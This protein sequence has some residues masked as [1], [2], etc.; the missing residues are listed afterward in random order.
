MRAIVR[1]RAQQLESRHRVHTARRAF[2][3]VDVLVSLG[4]IALLI[5]LMLPALTGI[6]E[7]SRKVVCSSNIRQIG[8][9][10]A[11]Y[12][13][14]YRRNVPFSRFYNKSWQIDQQF[15][16]QTLM[17]AKVAPPTPSAS[18]ANSWDGLGLLFRGNYCSAAQVYYCPSHK[19]AHRYD[20][21]ADGWYGGPID[22]YTNFQY[23]GG[24]A[25]GQTNLDKMGSRISLMADG[26]ASGLDFNH[27]IGGNIVASDLS[28]FWFD[29]SKHTLDL[30]TDY[31]D[32]TAKDKLQAAWTAI[33]QSINK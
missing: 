10:T 22:V 24:T 15:E 20:T 2:T 8:I 13:D 4:V 29:D 18:A 31:S 32:P 1:V 19:Y 11:M 12:A 21:Y 33:D 30:P 9:S 27:L 17:L 3:L 25:N 28:V 23:R 6:R 16:P 14:D 26:M 7:T 5:G